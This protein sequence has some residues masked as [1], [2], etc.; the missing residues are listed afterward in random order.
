VRKNFSKSLYCIQNK[1]TNERKRGLEGWGRVCGRA[2]K[3]A[4]LTFKVGPPYTKPVFLHFATPKS[5]GLYTRNLVI[6]CC[7]LNRVM[8][9]NT[10]FE[11][12]K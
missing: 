8:G 2:E 3:R 10:D 7:R 12:K 4:T 5:K 9:F 1:C 11:R 6:H